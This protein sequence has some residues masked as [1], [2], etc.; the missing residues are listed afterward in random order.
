[1]RTLQGPTLSVWLELPPI[2]SVSA[3]AELVEEDSH[4]LNLAVLVQ[5][6]FPGNPAGIIYQNLVHRGR[7]PTG[8]FGVLARLLSAVAARLL[9]DQI[10]ERPVRVRTTAVVGPLGPWRDV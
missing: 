10:R 4:I 1:M 5:E 7:H 6:A 2:G 3:S 9:W 8:R